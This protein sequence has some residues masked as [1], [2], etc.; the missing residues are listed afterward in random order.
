MD[1]DLS[2]TPAHVAAGTADGR[3]PL[4]ALEA[5]LA[6]PGGGAA[7]QDCLLHLARIEQ[8]LR[9]RITAGLPRAAYADCQAAIDALDAAAEVLRAWPA[10]ATQRHV[11]R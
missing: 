7:R 2:E 6:A 4:S 10:R 1:P 3:D 9:E 8:R 5:R 11:A